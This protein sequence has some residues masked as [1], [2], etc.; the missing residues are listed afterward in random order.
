MQQDHVVGPGGQR[1][2]NRRAAA[3]PA[4][5]E[6]PGGA[7]RLALELGV[8]ERLAVGDQGVAIGTGLGTLRQP[9]VQMHLWH[10]CE[11]VPTR[12]KDAP[13]RDTLYAPIE[14][15][16]A[17]SYDDILYERG[18]EIARITINRPEV[19]NAFRPQTIAELRDAFVR[20]R[21]DT[22]VGAIIFTGAGDEAFCSG[23]DQR[24]RGDDGYIGDDDVAR[25]GV[26]RLDVG[27]LH[28]QI[29]R[30]P[31]PI[32]A[33]VAGY[34]VGGGQILHLV[35]DLSIAAENAVF[36]QTG[37][38]VGSFDGGFGAGLLARAVGVARRRR[39]GFSAGSTT[40]TR[41]SRWGS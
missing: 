34:A 4:G 11:P 29:R 24:I 10:C 7:G 17:A 35:C 33:A 21:D 5:G 28:V 38:R 30:T 12:H 9:V 39:S 40:P 20:A 19:R 27:D 25:Q 36:G 41:R 3:S 13:D 37:P 6:P 26:G 15:S 1:E 22:G 23:G 32:L 8:G 18:E 16:E 31:K 2:R 14:W